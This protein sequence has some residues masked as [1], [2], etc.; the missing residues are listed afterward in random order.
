MV[1]VIVAF[2]LVLVL[3]LALVTT[4]HSGESNAGTQ[5][6]LRANIRSEDNVEE[7]HHRL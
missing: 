2:V 6:R 3:A 1:L 7:A 5:D 4:V